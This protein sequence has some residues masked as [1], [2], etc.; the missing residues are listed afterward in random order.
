MIENTLNCIYNF[1]MRILFIEWKSFGNDD[2][3]EAFEALHHSVYSFVFDGNKELHHDEEI[4]KDIK[5]ACILYG[6]DCVFSFNYYPIIAKACY[7]NNTTY[8]SW[9]YDNPYVLMYSHTIIYPTNHVFVFDKSQY[10][11]F[12]DNGITTVHYM[13]LAA[14]AGRLKKLIN[15][16]QQ[17]MIFEQSRW[18]NKA[19]IAFVGSLYTESHQFYDRMKNISDNTRGYLEGIM[20]A[21]KHIY[22]YNFIQSMLTEEVM[23]DMSRDLP[24]QPDPE[25]VESREYLFAEYVINRK[26]TAIER[27]EY[28]E[29]IAALV[30]YDGRP[31]LDLYTPDA[32]Y[33]LINTVNHG[34]VDYYDMAPFV[35]NSAKIN[36]NITLRS[37]HTGIPLRAFDILGAGGFLLT[38][39][40]QDFED[41]YVEG[42][43]YVA[44]DS[45]DNM[46]EKI[47]YYLSHDNERRDIAQHG[48]ETTVA[49]HTYEQRI[50]TMLEYVS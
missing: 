41:C 31:V 47:E 9:I 48:F 6:I 29:A 10:T 44:Y 3:K 1:Y 26:L 27:A 21:Q 36:V 40:Q 46:L 32:T 37:I 24:M 19:P 43:D 7:E 35:Y 14:N 13:P 33:K 49:K 50:K 15:N 20:E 4:E 25:G 45:I 16:P 18:K 2:I 5:E 12:A 38:N 8:L 23:N 39:Y 30:K 42:E 34:K 17:K 28:L 22:G 11:E